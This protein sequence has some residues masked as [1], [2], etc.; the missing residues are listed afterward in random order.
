M[1][2]W[3]LADVQQQETAGANAATSTG[4]AVV[5]SGT[6]H[7]KGAWVE[8]IAATSFET[9]WILLQPSLFE[10]VAPADWLIDIGIG[11]AG[12]E[13]VILA[14]VPFCTRGNEPGAGTPIPLSIP[15]GTRI[16]ARAQVSNGGGVA[17]RTARLLLQLFGSGFAEAPGAQ[18]AV[19]YGANTAD[20]GGVGVDPGAV[21]HTKG[22]WSEIV[23][24]T[25]FNHS[26]FILGIGNQ[27]NSARVAADWLVDIAVG[28][29]GSE[30]IILADLAA[31]SDGSRAIHPQRMLLP[32]KVP[33][34]SRL[35]A[36]G[37]CSTT[38]AIDRTFDV[39][40][41]GVS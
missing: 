2:D 38:D 40:L 15:A 36:R 26:C 39:I 23:A 32:M 33:A 20:S 9:S 12:S 14:N 13:Q 16:A 41:I 8:L 29:S 1:A 24:S 17:G 28:A 19:T 37:Q 6:N 18:L 5:S 21:A 4:K 25:S 11:P 31:W 3:R 22:A 10:A 35:A 7:V 34:G 27:A 30:Q